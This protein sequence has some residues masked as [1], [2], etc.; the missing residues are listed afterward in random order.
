MAKLVI[1]E[2]L[3]VNGKLTLRRV[4]NEDR[5]GF[6]IEGLL[7]THLYFDDINHIDTSR[8]SVS[9]IKVYEENFGSDDYNILYHFTADSIEVFGAEENGVFYILYGEEMKMIESEMYKNDH[10]TL[11][12]I[13]EEYKD[14]I[15]KDDERNEEEE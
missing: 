1:N 4:V 12:D 2:E 6:N 13:G 9:G 11:G 5:T 15:L 7:A 10:P 3:R 14:M 8:F